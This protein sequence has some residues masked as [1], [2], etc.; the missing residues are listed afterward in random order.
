MVSI[1]CITVVT[2]CP[3]V[4]IETHTCV[5]TIGTL[6]DDVTLARTVIGG[7]PSEGMLCDCNM[8]GWGT[9][10]MG[11]CVQV[12]LSFKPGEE[13][14]S[15]KPG[16]PTSASGDTSGGKVT[17]STKSAKELKAEAKEA[18]KQELKAKKV[19]RL[20]KKAQTAKAENG[21]GDGD[22]DGVF[23]DVVDVEKQEAIPTEEIAVLQI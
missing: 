21:D 8:L 22:G 9:G 2:S 19:A 3:N 5:A 12:P 16:A 6:I 1:A 18:R 23:T 17:I 20:A 15:S 10:S 7:I 4:R 13:A 11:N 14:P